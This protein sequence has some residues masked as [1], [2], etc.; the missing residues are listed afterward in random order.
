MNVEHLIEVKILTDIKVIKETLNRMGVGNL[1]KKILYPSCYLWENNGKQ[2]I[3]HFKQLFQLTRENAYNNLSLDDI[4]RVNAIIFN[5]KNWGLID[6][7]D[8]LILPH[9]KFI[10][11]LP[12]NQK[13]DWVISHK[14]NFKTINTTKESLNG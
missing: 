1:K 14:F 2:Y 5:L 3:V 4:E 13:Q 10:F 7:D 12:H 9:K 8:S 6:V 11:V